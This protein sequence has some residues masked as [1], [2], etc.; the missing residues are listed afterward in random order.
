MFARIVHVEH[1][2]LGALSPLLS[3]SLLWLCWDEI[4]NPHWTVILGSI[5]NGHVVE[6]GISHPDPQGGIHLHRPFGGGESTSTPKPTSTLD[7]VEAYC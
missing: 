3:I 2:P 6:T 5:G 1:T 7:L 4:S